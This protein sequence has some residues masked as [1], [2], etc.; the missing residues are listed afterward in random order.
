MAQKEEYIAALDIGSS[1]IK[2]VIAHVI[3]EEKPRIIGV[4]VANSNGIRKGMVV[5]IEEVSEAIRESI[6]KAEKNS[7][8]KI[9]SV[10]VSIG[11]N[12]I[13]SLETKGVVV[14]GRADGDVEQQ[15]VARAIEAAQA[16]NLPPNQEILHIIP[17]DFRLDNQEG[18][19]DP[20]GMNGIR[21][22]MNGILILGSVPHLRNITKCVENN[23]VAVEGFIISPLA[24]AKAVLNKRQ[25]ELGVGGN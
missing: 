21:L 20:V 3:S 13:S 15:D 25:K 5:D 6:E 4:G 7:G 23:G 10:Y 9:E 16:I 2:T 8:I 14:V 1:K 19:K 22:E 12:H 18:I 24:A 17:K 11:G